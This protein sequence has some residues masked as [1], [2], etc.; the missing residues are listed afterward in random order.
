MTRFEFRLHPVGP[1]LP[2][3]LIVYPIS[4]AKSVLQQ[5]RE[6]AATAPDEL[7]V[8][9]VLR[10]APP[11]PFLPEE[12]HGQG[13]VALALLYA[14]DP[15]Q[16]E[17]L[18]EPLRRFG[19]PVGQHVGVQPYTAWQQVFDPLLTAG[20][21]FVAALGGATGRPAA[22]SAAFGANYA[23]LAGVKRRVDPQN[24]FRIHQNIAP[25]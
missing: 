22:D 11:L 12:V 23:R 6:F 21:L 18:V 24:L 17:R 19:T 14:G 2:S 16:G 5:Y 20:A 13:I 15:Q 8:S 10:V 9:G 1:E 4:A 7:S 25:A 3:G